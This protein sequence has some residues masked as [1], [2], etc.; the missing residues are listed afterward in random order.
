MTNKIE[1]IID[2][3]R[4]G[5]SKFGK[6]LKENMLIIVILMAFLLPIYFFSIKPS[7]IIKNCYKKA[8]VDYRGHESHLTYNDN[9][10]DNCLKKSGINK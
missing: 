3:Y 7:H 4:P 10:Y 9:N 2:V 5:F 8:Y 6:F 1:G